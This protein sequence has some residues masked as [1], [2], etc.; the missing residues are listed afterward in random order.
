MGVVTLKPSR[1]SQDRREGFSSPPHEPSPPQHERKIHD[2]CRS[3]GLKTGLSTLS[4]NP[5]VDLVK[6]AGNAVRGSATAIGGDDYSASDFRSLTQVL[7]GQRG[8]ATQWFFNWLSSGLPQRE[9]KD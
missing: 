6:T 2:G 5:T 9:L 7:P 1:R 4:A 3:S 8:V